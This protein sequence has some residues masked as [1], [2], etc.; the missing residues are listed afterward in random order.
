MVLNYSKKKKKPINSFRKESLSCC[1]VLHLVVVQSLSGVPLFT[2]PW[3]ITHQASLSFTVSQSLL[4][5]MS[6]VLMM[7]SNHL[8]LS[9]PLLLLPSVFPSIRVFSIE[10]ALCIKWP[11]YQSFSFSISPSSIQGWFPLGLTGLI[12]LLPKG[13]LRVLHQF[14]GAQPSLWSTFCM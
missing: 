12:S 14:F 7:P 3:T 2:T 6:I 13:L 11:K 4:R 8:I 10:S 5:L 9:C 1:T